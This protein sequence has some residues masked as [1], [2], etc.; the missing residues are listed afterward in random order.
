MSQVDYNGANWDK[1]LRFAYHGKKYADGH[2]QTF[3]VN[4]FRCN[5]CGFRIPDGESITPGVCDECSMPDDGTVA[6]E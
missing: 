5:K 2:E 6:A 3:G 1:P 4:R